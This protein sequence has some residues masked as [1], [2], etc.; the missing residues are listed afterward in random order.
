M[1]AYC[2]STAGCQ[3]MLEGALPLRTPSFCSFSP[4]YSL[5]LLLK[6]P[7]FSHVVCWPP[8]A[9]MRSPS[10]PEASLGG[11][12][13]LLQPLICFLMLFVGL[14]LPICAVPRPLK[15]ALVGVDLFC[16]AG[17]FSTGLERGGAIAGQPIEMVRASSSPPS[18]VSSHLPTSPHLT[19]RPC[20]C[21]GR[22]LSLHALLLPQ[23]QSLV[24]LRL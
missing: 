19:P 13:P 21:Y 12:G 3:A 4:L 14:P 8:A 5:L 1:A 20:L 6:P 24:L 23:L 22:I 17:G 11:G 15:P 2:S 10:A 9:E 16:G 18:R 7:L